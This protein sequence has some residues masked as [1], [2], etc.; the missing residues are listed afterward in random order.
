MADAGTQAF[1]LFCEDIRRESGGKQSLLGV[2]G[3]SLFVDKG[4]EKVEKLK[5]VLIA[6]IKDTRSVTVSLHVTA[7]VD[8]H[9]VKPDE[10]YS[11]TFLQDDDDRQ[12]SWT[13]QLVADLS[14]MP[15]GNDNA[16]IVVFKVDETE[17]AAGLQIA[18]GEGQAIRDGIVKDEVGGQSTPIQPS[19]NKRKRKPRKAP[20]RVAAD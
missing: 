6:R 11:A 20:D 7:H 16:V 1:V 15:L 19:K 5:A 4:T 18:F 12:D 2:L 14:G 13:L 3:G 9:V 10:S 8:D 17:A